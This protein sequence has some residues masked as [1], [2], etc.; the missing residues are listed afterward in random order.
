MLRGQEMSGFTLHADLDIDRSF[1][2]YSAE[3]KPK[4]ALKKI[5]GTI[6]LSMSKELLDVIKEDPKAMITYMMYRPK[7]KLGQRIYHINIGDGE[8]KLNGKPVKF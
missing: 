3:M 6:F 7:R 8:L 1:N 4:Y 2:I 5:D